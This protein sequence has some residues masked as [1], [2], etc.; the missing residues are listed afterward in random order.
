[1]GS[2]TKT[3]DKELARLIRARGEYIRSLKDRKEADT[4]EYDKQISILIAKAKFER[5]N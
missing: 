2:I 3:V 1:M 5:N 4:R